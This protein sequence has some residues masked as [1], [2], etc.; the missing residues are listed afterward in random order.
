MTSTV[1]QMALLAA[2]DERRREELI[3]AHEQLILRTASSVCRRYVGRSDDG[4]SIALGAFSRAVDVY[5]EDKGDFPCGTLL[6]E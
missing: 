4:W 5:N 1:N 6:C 2:E 3:H